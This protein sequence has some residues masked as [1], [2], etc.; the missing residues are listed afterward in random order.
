M[1]L[2][3]YFSKKKPVDYALYFNLFETIYLS[4]PQAFFWITPFTGKT[5]RYIITHYKESFFTKYNGLEIVI[6][7]DNMMTYHRLPGAKPDG[8]G[9]V[10]MGVYYIRVNSMNEAQESYFHINKINSLDLLIEEISFDAKPG[11]RYQHLEC[12][13]IAREL[14]VPE[15]IEIILSGLEW[16]YRATVMHAVPVNQKLLALLCNS[17]HAPIDARI[18]MLSLRIIELAGDAENISATN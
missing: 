13:S 2:L 7:D 8:R 4:S 17:M 11:L 18:K 15:L 6:V 16:Q 9:K 5:G 14:F 3:N 10:E 12:R 1:S